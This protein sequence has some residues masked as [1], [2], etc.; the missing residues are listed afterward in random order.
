MSN[1]NSQSKKSNPKLQETLGALLLLLTAII[2]GLAFVAQSKGMESVG[3]FTFNGV[4][5]FVGAIV[6]IP[7]LVINRHKIFKYTKKR[8]HA[9]TPEQTVRRR[10]PKQPRSRTETKQ[11]QSRTGTKRLQ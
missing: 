1:G 10:E 2:W 4:R 5:S 9:A 7:V 8:R 11:L 6:L 3:P